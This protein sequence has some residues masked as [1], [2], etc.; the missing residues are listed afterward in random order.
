MSTAS[1]LSALGISSH[2][3]RQSRPRSRL[4][5]QAQN[6]A[7]QRQGKIWKKGGREGPKWRERTRCRTWLPG[8]AVDPDALE[9]YPFV[10]QVNAVA[11]ERLGRD[12]VER[13]AVRA[14][15]EAGVVPLGVELLLEREV[16]VPG[17]D[18]LV[19]VRQRTQPLA[20]AGHLV[21]LPRVREVAR[22][23]ENVAVGD[24]I[25][26]RVL[27]PVRVRDAHD[28]HSPLRL[29]S[30]RQAL[31]RHG[32]HV[33]PLPV[34]RRPRAIDVAVEL[35]ASGQVGR[36]RHRDV[37]WT[38]GGAV[39]GSEHKKQAEE[40]RLPRLERSGTSE[41]GEAGGEKRLETRGET[42]KERKKEGEGRR[43]KGG[44]EGGRRKE[45][46]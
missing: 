8:R 2:F 38:G 7:S 9:R 17:N 24:W 42:T 31:Q 32:V 37:W 14:A 20:E 44:R 21:R 39:P 22:V 11:E 41:A 23:H 5:A 27:Q 30:I 15:V 33:R 43:R 25:R 40:R 28:P 36:D 45:E 26:H 19:L 29:R 18:H 12:G 3:K 46:E 16:V 4:N 6:S 1:A 34:H 10:F 13:G 35:V